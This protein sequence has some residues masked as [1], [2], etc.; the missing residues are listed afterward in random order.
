MPYLN[1]YYE[2]K[3]GE[4]GEGV[5]ASPDGYSSMLDEH[6]YSGGIYMNNHGQF[7]LNDGTLIMLGSRYEMH[8]YHTIRFIYVDVNGYKRGPNKMGIDTYVLEIMQNGELLPVGA[9]GTYD[10]GACNEKNSAGWYNGYDCA[11]KVISEN[12]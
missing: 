11:Y 9:K 6:N 8:M 12:R 4:E 1:V 5:C 3:E 10:S 2:C 7:V